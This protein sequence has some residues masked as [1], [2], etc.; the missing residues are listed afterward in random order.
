MTTEDVFYFAYVGF[1]LWYWC[2]YT[3]GK[4][5]EKRREANK[6]TPNKEPNNDSYK[7]K[8]KELIFISNITRDGS[9]TSFLEET[10]MKHLD[11]TVFNINCLS[12]TNRTYIASEFNSYVVRYKDCKIKEN[13]FI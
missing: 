9:G 2:G 10:D 4:K 7:A 13:G 1:A 8:G 11:E 12:I 5:V 6:K 3:V